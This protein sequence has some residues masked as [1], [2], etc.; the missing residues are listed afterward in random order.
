MAS[1]GLAELWGW[2]AEDRNKNSTVLTKH[3]TCFSSGCAF[4][5]ENTYLDELCQMSNCD[6]S[7]FGEVEWH[8]RWLL[9]NNLALSSLFSFPH[10]LLEGSPFFF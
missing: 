1:G 8:S 9:L 4:T 10:V 3:P 2:E 7:G 6:I 5:W